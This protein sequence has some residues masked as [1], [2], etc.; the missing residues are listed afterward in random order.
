ME[1]KNHE[2]YIVEIENAVAETTQQLMNSV[3][4]SNK[5]EYYKK[6]A[7]KETEI[8]RLKS[9]QQGNNKK[10]KNLRNLLATATEE[11]KQY[12][13]EVNIA[14]DEYDK[15]KKENA[16]LKKQ[17]EV[18]DDCA[19][20]ACVDYER[21]ADT[22]NNDSANYKDIIQDLEERIEKLEKKNEELIKSVFPQK[23][24]MKPMRSDIKG[25]INNIQKTYKVKRCSVLWDAIEE[26]TLLSQENEDIK[27][28]L[29]YYHKN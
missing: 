4:F 11:I 21:L 7:E 9:H 29:I 26:L 15:L 5:E 2:Q 8:C 25:L 23:K 10:V 12:Q 27:N 3:V 13:E 24:G 17:I 20:T 16:K 22:Y 1:N 18:L 19:Q 28:K 14:T 6:L